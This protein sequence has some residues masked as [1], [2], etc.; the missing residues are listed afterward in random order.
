MTVRIGLILLLAMVSVSSTSLVVRSVATVPALVLA[1][2]RM[3]T[4]SGMLWGYSVIR[5]AGSLS[6]INKKRIIFAGIFLGCH[7][8]CFFLGIR[9][10]S[11]ANATLLGCVAPIFT[12][13]IS[14][15]QKKKINKM[16][17]VGLIIA[18]VGGG[19]V[20][21]GDISLNSAN[22]F[23][24]SIALLSALFLAITFVLA[25]EIR[26]ETANV[27]YGRSLFFVASI[28]VLFIAATAGD[29]ILNF[30]PG[31]IPWFLFLGLVPSIFGHNLL[32]YAVKYITPTAVSS[33]PLGEPIIASLFG[34]LLFGE[35]IPF[36]ALLGGPI[37][38]IGVYI[39]I[40]HQA[41]SAD[42]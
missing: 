19:I 1:F 2:W 18:I 21:S 8:A 20:Q 30:K 25:E 33:V 32:N 41:V 24:N 35:A 11:I 42:D 12:V 26:Q 28:T 23:G 27:V 16:T 39:I 4:A 40:K 9:N 14:I 31:D 36:G 34:L 17:Y 15:F 22:L 13:I 29:S 7:F 10:T 37:V 38:L 5:P 3:F 6:L